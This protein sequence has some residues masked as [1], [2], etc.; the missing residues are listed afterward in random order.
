MKRCK[1]CP[2]WKEHCLTNCMPGRGKGGGVLLL[3]EAP[4]ANEDSTGKPF[5]GRAGKILEAALEEV[6]FRGIPLFFTNACRCRPLNNRQPKIDEVRTCRFYHLDQ[7]ID[8][9]KPRLII[10]LG[11]TPAMS[12]MDDHL[13]SVDKCRGRITKYKGIPVIYTYHPM[14]LSYDR[15]KKDY[16]LLDLRRAVTF[17]RN[18]CKVVEKPK[19]YKILPWEKLAT[20][21][22]G[23]EVFFD[24]ETRGLDPYSPEARIMCISAAT[25]PQTAFYQWVDM[26]PTSA[27][28]LDV[29]EP[30]RWAIK[31]AAHNGVFDFA[32]STRACPSDHWIWGPNC[33]WEDTIIELQYRDEHYANTS[34]EHLSRVYTDVRKLPM[35][36]WLKEGCPE[37]DDTPKNRR[38]L[39]L[40]NC[41]DS[42]C[43]YRLKHTLELPR[44]SR[45]YNSYQWV[46]SKMKTAVLMRHS[47]IYLH[48]KRV[49]ELYR[50]MTGNMRKAE[51]KL[52]KSGVDIHS[53]LDI[54][55]HLFHRLKLP[56]LATTKKTGQPQLTKEI[57]E[58]LE[59]MDKTDWVKHYRSL[60]TSAKIRDTYCVNLQKWG[61][62]AHPVAYV[63]R[64]KEAGGEG[65]TDT[66]RVTVAGFVNLPRKGGVKRCLTSRYGSNG[67]IVVADGQQM[68][69]R[70]LADLSQDELLLDAIDRKEDIHRFVAGQ[71]YNVK[72]ERVSDD[73]RH[74]GKT[75]D[76]T[77]IYGGGASTIARRTGMSKDAAQKLI[78]LYFGRFKGV[79]SYIQR[80]HRIA[81]KERFL[82]SPTGRPIH[83]ENASN[84][85]AKDTRKSV[86]TPIQGAANEICTEAGTN[87][88]YFLQDRGIKGHMVL[89]VYD[90]I[91]L[92]VHRAYWTK[93]VQREWIARALT[94]RPKMVMRSLGWNIK[95]PLEWDVKTGRSLGEAK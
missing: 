37:K 12:M 59:P 53:T 49:E 48:Q 85:W 92:D 30:L 27:D 68:E 74:L 23:K 24:L 47:G 84:E 32:W 86:N 70:V 6:D 2:I 3:G 58:Q 21:A 46:C 44:G 79:A 39:K 7:E 73:Q 63:G 4:G 82:L 77:L 94:Y 36:R 55:R 31:L 35:P 25:D 52:L 14:A 71:I 19:P 60:K 22:V 87:S 15:R 78:D 8:R 75:I 90:S 11:Q 45:E 51:N 66:G 76:F 95:V 50:E 81:I 38:E 29:I 65:G 17:Y 93:E 80:Q 57:L 56:V 9:I 40:Y 67:L 62:I 89:M 91:V 33:F 64:M 42:I 41:R 1:K 20:A 28:W 43:G 18:G 13:A 83:L 61:R 88:Q 5:V 26:A 54:H 72:P 10:S 34:L 16:F 69:I